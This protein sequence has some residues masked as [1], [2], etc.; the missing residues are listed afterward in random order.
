MLPLDGRA[1]HIVRV[2]VIVVGVLSLL[3]YPLR[4]SEPKSHMPG[5]SRIEAYAIV[6]ADGMLADANRRIP[7]SLKVEADQKFF[8]SALDRAAAVVHGRHSH[9]GGPDAA[10]PPADRDE[11]GCRA[12]ARHAPSELAVVES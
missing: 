1:K 9:E 5:P 2:V 7:D 10:P 3:R 12:G 8:H 11:Q 4:C 6:S